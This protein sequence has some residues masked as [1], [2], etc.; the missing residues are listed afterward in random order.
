VWV[1]G[2]WVWRP[3]LRRYVWVPGYYH[4][5]AQAG[6]VWVPGYWGWSPGLGY[7]WVEGHWRPQ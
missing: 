4:V 7:H 5:P 3:W 1:P 6:Y 2:A